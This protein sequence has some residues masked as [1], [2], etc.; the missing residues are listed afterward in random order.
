MKSAWAAPFATFRVDEQSY[1]SVASHLGE[2]AFCR[3]SI[4]TA[5]NFRRA[6]EMAEVVRAE[7]TRR[8]LLL[9]AAGLAGAYGAGR[10]WRHF[11]LGVKLFNPLSAD[12]FDLPPVPG[13]LDA[14]GAP[15]PGFSAASINGQTVFLNAFASW[16]PSCI[17]EH[18][19]LMEF[20][21]SGAKIHGVAS[22]DDPAQTLAFLQARGNP[23]VK[24][25]VDRKGQL[26]RALGA[27]GI[28]ASFVMA[29]APQLSLMLQGPQDFLSLR[30]KIGP[31]FVKG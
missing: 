7:R 17:E 25:G 18:S 4:L 8:T 9:G 5:W 23:F 13:L 16:C 14:S 20:A 15:I 27:R 2:A 3:D 19:A 21:R 10:V 12:H 31:A 1:L 24:V 6:D 29:P 26:Y 22:L 28:P 30:D 11:D